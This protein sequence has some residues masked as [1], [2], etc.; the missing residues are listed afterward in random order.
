MRALIPQPRRR[1][2]VRL[3][4]TVW[5]SVFFSPTVYFLLLLLADRFHIVRSP[6]EIFVASLF[7][8]IPLI[9]LLVCGSVV[10]LS[11]MRAAR[12]IGW[13]LFTLFAMLLQFGILL[14]IIIMATGFAPTQ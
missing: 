8:L 1:L 3:S 4:L 14:A 13:M 11:S 12:K 5:L 9:A 6:P 2:P 10:W 7:Y